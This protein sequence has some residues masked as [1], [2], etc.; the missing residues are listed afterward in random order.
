MEKRYTWHKITADLSTAKS[1]DAAQI[2]DVQLEG[3]NICVVKKDE[4]IF[5][6]A[7]RCLHAGGKLSEGNIDAAGNIVCPV[8]RYK[9]RLTNGYNSS[10]EGFFLKTYPVIK[11]D[12][13]VFIGLPVDLFSI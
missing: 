10:G 5:A 1:A 3:K 12:E 7:A 8:H 9:F 2:I 6:C 11:N 13:G 4:K